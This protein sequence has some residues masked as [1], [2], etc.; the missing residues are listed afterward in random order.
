MI[1]RLQ[2]SRRRLCRL[3]MY[4]ETIYSIYMCIPIYIYY[5]DGRPH[6]I[7]V[8]SSRRRRR[9]RTLSV[10]RKLYRNVS[11]CILIKDV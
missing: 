1:Y 5:Y 9:R 3:V 2:I 4:I 8:A 6:D 11:Y 10:S 7:S